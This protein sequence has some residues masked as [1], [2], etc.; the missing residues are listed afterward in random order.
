VGKTKVGGIDFNKARIR[1][2]TEAVIALSV[3]PRGFTASQLAA[4]VRDCGDADYQSRQAAYD[5]KKLRGKEL[6]RRLGTTRNYEPTGAGLRTMTALLVLRDKVI[7]PLLS[8]SIQRHPAHGAQNP[9]SL[10]IH[11]EALRVGMQG[12]FRELGLAA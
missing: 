7:K 8:A 11:Y 3:S 2:V 12:V 1:H 6:V 4:R 9:T 10:H 5:L